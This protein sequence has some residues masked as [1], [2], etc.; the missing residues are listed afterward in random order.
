LVCIWCIST[1]SRHASSES[2]VIT[3]ENLEI[4]NANAAFYRMS[5]L[6]ETRQQCQPLARF[7]RVKTPN[8]D[9]LEDLFQLISLRVG[10]CLERQGLLE[11]DA[12][13]A[14]L[15]PDPAEDTDAVP[16]PDPD[17]SSGQR[18]GWREWTSS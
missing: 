11:Q 2:I 1:N 4:I 9:E 6:A 15:D 12:E 13:N 18:S 17:S 16:R 3:D 14:C 8:K 7:Q 10:C 5:G